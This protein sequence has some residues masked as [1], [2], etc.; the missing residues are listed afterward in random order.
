MGATI[1]RDPPAIYLDHNATTPLDPRVAAAMQESAADDFN[2][3]SA[4]GF[5]RRAKKRLEDARESILRAVGAEAAAAD[6]L[7]FTSGGTE[8]NNMALRCLAG[9]VGSRIIVSAIEHPSILVTAS[10]LRSLGHDV[11]V[12]PVDPHG[13]LQLD[14]LEQLLTPKTRLVSVMLANHETGAV[15]P[16]AEVVRLCRSRG[17]LVHTDA[18]QCVGKMQVDFTA[19]GV[20]ALTLAPHKFYGPRGIGGLVCRPELN[21]TPILFGGPQQGGAR[22]GTESVALAVG[23]EHALALFEG[24]QPPRAVQ[25]AARRDQLESGL[26]RLAVPVV[27]PGAEV[28]RTPQTCCVSFPGWNRQALIMSLDQ[29][30]FACSSGSA[31]ASGSSEPSPVLRAMGLPDEVIKGAI[32]FSVGRSTTAHE[33]DMVVEAVRQILG[34]S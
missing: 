5:G 12:A 25:L 11:Q 28:L 34:R 31:C 8:A 3:S 32:R 10:H 14:A 13:V 33:I 1:E 26:Q 21:L 6:R 7:I 16:V 15:Q 22:A 20:S 29:A 23:M 17:I 30:G 4:H 19:L 9:A 18:V 2:P 24:E 27:F